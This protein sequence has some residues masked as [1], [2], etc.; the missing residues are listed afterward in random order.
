[1][2]HPLAACAS[3][4]DTIVGQRL[5]R[6]KPHSTFLEDGTVLE[7]NQIFAGRY[8]IVRHLAEGGMGVIFEAEHLTTEAHVAL[9]LLW[10]HVMHV[11]SARQRFE[12]EAKVAARV[13]SEHIVRVLD[14]GFDRHVAKPIEPAEL[15][16]ALAELIGTR[17]S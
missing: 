3:Q 1:M 5:V 13:N 10:P 7:P 2:R 14:A 4:R 6:V 8:R 12:L 16:R 17:G 11:A 9:K 15:V